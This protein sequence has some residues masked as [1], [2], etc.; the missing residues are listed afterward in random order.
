MSG[1]HNGSPE[2]NRITSNCVTGHFELQETSLKM[3]KHG[4][5]IN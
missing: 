5:I 1:V 2:E 3:E 4:K